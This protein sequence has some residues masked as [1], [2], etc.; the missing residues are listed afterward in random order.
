M[1]FGVRVWADRIHPNGYAVDC[2]ACFKCPSH[3]AHFRPQSGVFAV[4]HVLLGA[5]WGFLGGCMVRRKELVLTHWVTELL[6]ILG[7]S[8]I[9]ALS[10]ALSAMSI[11]PHWS[12]TLERVMS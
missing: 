12:C 11:P 5:L 2:G 10:P 7:S 1:N 9:I 4:G 3:S 6:V 8:G